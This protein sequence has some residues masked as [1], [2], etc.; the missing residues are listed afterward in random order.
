MRYAVVKGKSASPWDSIMVA[1]MKEVIYF[2]PKNKT[3][4]F[5]SGRG[6]QKITHPGGRIL[7]FH[8]FLNAGPTSGLIILGLC[9]RMLI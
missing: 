5:S 3:V 9:R 1:A 7:F 6:G 8:S 2:M 4:L